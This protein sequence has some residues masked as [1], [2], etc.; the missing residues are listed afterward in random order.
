MYRYNY[1][2]TFPPDLAEFKVKQGWIYLLEDTADTRHL[3]VGKSSDVRQRLYSYNSVRAKSYCRYIALAGCFEDATL[4]ESK[5][6]KHLQRKIGAIEGKKEWFLSG[7]KEY[8]LWV[9]REGEKEF[10]LVKEVLID[11]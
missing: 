2:T 11:G 4:A 1:T 7:H 8:I 6:L 3:K 5:I 9:M 10:P